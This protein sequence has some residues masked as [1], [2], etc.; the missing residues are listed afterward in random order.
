MKRLL[1]RYDNYA[2]SVSVTTRQPRP[3]EEDGREYFFRTREEVEKMIKEDQ[4]LEY[5]QYVDNYYGTPRFL[6]R[7]NAFSGKKCNS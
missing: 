6:C 5:A 2:L 1:E 7:R 3:G 4:L